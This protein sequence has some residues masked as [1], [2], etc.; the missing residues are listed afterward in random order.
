MGE[1]DA[2]VNALHSHRVL[3]VLVKATENVEEFGLGDARN[4][5]DHVVQHDRGLLAYLWCLVLRDLIVHRH[6]FLL[7]GRAHVRVDDWEEL[8]CREFRREAVAVH[9]SLYHAHDA[10]FE[11]SDLDHLKNFLDALCRLSHKPNRC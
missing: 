11:V 6:Y 8:D 3:L 7:I 1:A 2:T 4:Q 5:L 9:Q 10:A